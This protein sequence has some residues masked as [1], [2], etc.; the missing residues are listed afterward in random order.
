MIPNILVTAIIAGIVVA[1][2]AYI[3]DMFAARAGLG[4]PRQFIWLIAFVIWLLWV[5]N[6]GVNF[7]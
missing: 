4:F 7:V 2:I 6:G 5:F 1:V 3:A